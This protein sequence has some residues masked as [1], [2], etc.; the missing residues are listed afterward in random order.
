MKMSLYT[1][2]TII[3]QLDTVAQYSDTVDAV[4]ALT[5]SWVD[6]VCTP[7]RMV[8]DTYS[9]SDAEHRVYIEVP[10]CSDHLI[11]LRQLY[12]KAKERIEQSSSNEQ[13]RSEAETVSTSLQQ[14][15][16]D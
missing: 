12:E 16:K 2:I 11:T 4:T 15:E 1:A 3:D 5:I 6:A 8:R 9:R 10:V 14:P 7:V 13:D